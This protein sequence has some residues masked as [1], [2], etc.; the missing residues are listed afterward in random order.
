MHLA[1]Y[2]V[3]DNDVRTGAIVRV[4]ISPRALA[5]LQ[6]NGVIVHVHVT[7]MNQHILADIKVDGIARRSTALGVNGRHILCGS[8]DETAQV[9]HIL[10]TVEVIR[11]KR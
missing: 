6:H 8:I 3:L 2:A 10:A 7:A 4:L 9:S 5:A 1:V 11:P